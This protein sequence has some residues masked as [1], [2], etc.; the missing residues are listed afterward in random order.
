MSL[1]T[2]ISDLVTRIATEFKTVKS[3]ISGNN[4][5]D[6]S[7][8]NTSVKTSLLSAINE[9]VSS[10]AGKQNAIGFIPENTAYKGAAN[11]YAP[12]DASA[13]VPAINLPSYVDDVLEFA[14]L[15]GFPATGEAGKIY[16]AIDTNKT[17]R[18]SGTVYVF[19]TSG[20]V[21][22]VAGKTG[23]V[24]LVKADVGLS[25]VDN[26]ADTAKAV[27]SAAKLT[28]PR[29]INGAAFDGTADI[30]INQASPSAPGSMSA[31]DKSKL[32][33]VAANANN[34]THPANHAP[35]VIAQ[36]T[37]NRFVSD[38]EKTAWNAKGNSNL[39]LGETF[40]NAYRGDRGKTAYDHSQAAHAPSD[41][42]NYVHPA[43]HPASV[44][45]QDANN[46]FVSDT[47]KTTWNSKGSSNLALGETSVTAHRGD[48][49]KS[50]YDHSQAAHAP[51]NA[52][53]AGATGDAHAVTAHAPSNAQKNSDITK[54]E[55]EAKLTGEISTHSHAGGAG[56][57]TSKSSSFSLAL[58]DADKTIRLTNSAAINITIPTNASVAFPVGTMIS[59][60]IIGDGV[61]TFIV[62]SGVTVT[63]E[64]LNAPMYGQW[65]YLI[66]TAT[67]TWDSVNLRRLTFP[68]GDPYLGGKIAHIFESGQT[69]F[70]AG[71]T[72]GIICADI[73]YSAPFGANNLAAPSIQRLTVG[74]AKLNCDEI[75]AADAAT[76]HG[77][78]LAKT[79]VSKGVSGWYI[80]TRDELNI[81]YTNR[82]ALG[83]A[84]SGVYLASSKAN[85]NTD[86]WALNFG[87]NTWGNGYNRTTSYNS[88]PI[89]YF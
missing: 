27:A 49:G 83:I 57:S 37:N 66:K 39:E 25:N 58:V 78:Y 7:S 85:G 60:L 44:I 47:E 86:A 24:T 31:S 82:V 32:D 6:L 56:G 34:Y 87:S 77:S 28:T 50:A 74:T 19:I 43:N 55:I 54:A 8:L 75:I 13:L 11:G 84:A 45:T 40:S 22:S 65:C 61:G 23:V 14:N 1:Q 88:R 30:V 15:A 71:E 73:N 18:W 62:S 10:I 5:G 80:P 4:S 41:A 21:D 35:S 63:N 70:V 38:A 17:Y 53:A 33:N 76:T 81:L 79:H 46:R 89:K 12:L 20:A 3:K 59:F 68:V 52:T 9:L 48:Q 36:D 64:G 69:G 67:N 16:V 26:T 42:N 72:H 2:R 51:A 29:T